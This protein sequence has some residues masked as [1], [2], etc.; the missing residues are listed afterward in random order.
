MRRL[1]FG[2]GV[3]IN[4]LPVTQKYLVFVMELMDAGVCMLFCEDLKLYIIILIPH[5]NR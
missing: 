2:L 5:H 1:L 3:V 4:A